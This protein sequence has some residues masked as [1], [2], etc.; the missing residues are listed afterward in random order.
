MPS[1]VS[2]AIEVLRSLPG[3]QQEAVARSILDYAAQ[4]DEWQ[5]TD[6]QV[7]EVQ[8]RTANRNRRVFS[9]AEARRRTRH[10]DA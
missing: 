9:V 6:D 3:D 7:A 4:D 8:R 5:L 1:K 2:E 10:L